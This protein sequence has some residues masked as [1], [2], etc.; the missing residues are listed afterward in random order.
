[1]EDW[2]IVAKI[3]AIRVWYNTPGRALPKHMELIISYIESLEEYQ[4]LRE[5]KDAQEEEISESYEIFV[6]AYFMDESQQKLYEILQNRFR[7]AF[8]NE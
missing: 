3:E 1:M 2:D 8:S 4:N 6:N 7:K 5:L